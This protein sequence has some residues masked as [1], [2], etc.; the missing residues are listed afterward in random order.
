MSIK[1]GKN[2]YQTTLDEALTSGFPINIRDPRYLKFKNNFEGAI[3]CVIENGKFQDLCYWNLK[4]WVYL[5]T[6]II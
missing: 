5:T 2:R 6:K 3:L 4:E 1:Y